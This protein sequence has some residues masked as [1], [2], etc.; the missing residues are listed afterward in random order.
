[1]FQ[2]FGSL[3]LKCLYIFAFFVKI[4][5]S[6]WNYA[7]FDIK[8]LDSGPTGFENEKSFNEKCKKRKNIS[9]TKGI[10]L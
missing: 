5:H 8:D 3:T 1:M 10:A 7:A 6:A 2:C 4:F 9:K